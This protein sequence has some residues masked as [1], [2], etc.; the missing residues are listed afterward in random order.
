MSEK[1]EVIA[2]IARHYMVCFYSK[3]RKILTFLLLSILAGFIFA[4]PSYCWRLKD[5]NE[6]LFDT[7]GEDGDIIL[8]RFSIHNKIK[9]CE[10]EIA[11]FS[12]AQWN[13]ETSEWE[14]ITAGVEIGR[15]FWQWL[16]IGQSVQS[17][18]LIHISEPTRPY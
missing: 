18:S 5:R 1:C 8:N 15:T 4:D 3:M 11:A 17:L 10:L 13:V 2:C 6:Y 7:R 14:K 16:Y 9:T 12:E